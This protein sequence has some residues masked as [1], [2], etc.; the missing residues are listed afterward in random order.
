M[1]TLTVLLACAF[2]APAL[3]SQDSNHVSIGPEASTHVRINGIRILPAPGKPFSGADSVDW[4][5]TLEDG[6]VVATHYDAKLARDSQGRIY[7]ERVSR[8]P[9]NSGQKSQVNEILVM[10]PVAHTQTTCVV[11][12][13]HCTVTGYHAPASVPPPRAVS[14]DD[15]KRSV[16]RESLGTD[17]IDDL[18]VVGTRETVTISTG[19]EGNSQPL[20]SVE[21]SWYS[22]DLEVN[23]SITRKDPREGTL[24]IHV[25]DLSRSEP[26]PALCQVPANF[27]V[28]D[29]RR[30]AKPENDSTQ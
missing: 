2:L 1:R 24:V 20:T 3:P 23:L 8:F 30:P 5:R 16:S 12:S 15:G 21:E 26:D 25:V 14:F 28:A 11:V 13:R 18:N 6:S 17:V 7:R 19:V 27:V 22:P 10:D 29:A 4:T 9:A